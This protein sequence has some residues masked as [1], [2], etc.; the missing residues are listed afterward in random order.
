MGE[1]A[2]YSYYGKNEEDEK[3]GVFGFRVDF[4]K[5]A[6]IYK[7]KQANYREK[8]SHNYL[9]HLHFEHGGKQSAKDGTQP[10]RYAHLPAGFDIQV[11]LFL[12]DGTCCNEL[13]QNAYAG[14]TVGYVDWKT[15][16]HKEAVGE[17]GGH[18]RYGVDEA[19]KD[20]HGY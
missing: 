20:A 17:G 10:Y 14:C 4:G 13:K 1:S 19:H 6:L 5:A 16:H 3:A 2:V 8:D 15:H 9:N 7:K 11:A 12:K 18:P